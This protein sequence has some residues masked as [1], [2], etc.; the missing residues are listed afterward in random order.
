MGSNLYKDY[1]ISFIWKYKSIVFVLN[2]EYKMYININ[3][4]IKRFNFLDICFLGG[5]K[6]IILK[7]LLF[8]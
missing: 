4:K 1:I 2:L 7:W 6:L 3:L 5:K 8:L